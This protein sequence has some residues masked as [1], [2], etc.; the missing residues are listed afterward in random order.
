ML[1]VLIL[2]IAVI[3]LII[4]FTIKQKLDDRTYIKSDIDNTEYFVRNLNDKKKSSNLLAELKQDTFNFINNLY[5][6]KKN[7]KHYESYIEQLYNN[8]KDVVFT[9]NI[10]GDIYTSYSL[11]KGE[12]IVFCLRNKNTDQIHDKNLITYVLLHELAHIACPD[13]GHTEKFKDIFNFIATEAVNQ[14]LYEKIDF[15][16]NPQEYCGMT[17]NTSII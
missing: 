8:M 14:K 17:L 3:I 16:N 15:Q 2:I 13:Y 1:L 12:K 5:I 11:N 9:E 7:Y 10:K 4:F 6:N